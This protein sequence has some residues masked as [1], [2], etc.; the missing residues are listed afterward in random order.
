MTDRPN[1]WYT[2]K[3]WEPGFDISRHQTE[4]ATSVRIPFLTDPH[5]SRSYRFGIIVNT[6]NDALPLWRGEVPTD[7][8]VEAV[9]SIRNAYVD[10]WFPEPNA[11]RAEM[12][13]F[14]PYD[15]EGG[16]PCYYVLKRADGSW[17]YHRSQ[18]TDSR[19]LPTVEE[20]SMTLTELIDRFED[21]QWELL[22]RLGAH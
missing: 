8:E 17:A 19:F 11:F 10:Y 12:E 7:Q 9:A 22:E 6:D 20:P 5:P 2:G 21:L 14:A 4:F 15:I 13:A 18:W 1:R 16:K 3:P